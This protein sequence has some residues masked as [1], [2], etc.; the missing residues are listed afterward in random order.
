MYEW[1]GSTW[2]QLT[3]LWES[4]ADVIVYTKNMFFFLVWVEQSRSF[5]VLR[6]VLGMQH[7]THVLFSIPESCIA[8]SFKDIYSEWPT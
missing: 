6:E 4:N 8:A 2:D 5:W 1:G 3:W 7:K